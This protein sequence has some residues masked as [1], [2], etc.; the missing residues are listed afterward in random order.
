MPPAAVEASPAQ[1]QSWQSD[2]TAIGTLNASQGV[3][4]TPEISGRVTGVFFHSGDSVQAGTPLL[5]LNPDTLKAQLEAAKAKAELSAA[6]YKRA[7]EL[8]K[9]QV[10]AQADLDAALSTYQS[11]LAE[12]ANYQAQLNQTLLRAPFA[13]RLGLRMVDLGDYVHAGD[14]VA[15]LDAIDPLRID[16][17]VPEVDLGQVQPGQIVLVHASAYPK[18]TFQGQV[19]ALDSQIEPNT[20]SLGVR[21]S[22]PNKDQK[23]LPGGFVEVNIQTG[24]PQKLITVAETAIS[25]DT[26]GP[27]VY[28]VVDKKAVK[29]KVSLGAHRNGQVAVLTGLKVGDVV[30]TAGEFKITDGAPVMVEKS[31]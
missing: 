22:I 21:A 4:V 7:T 18:Q 16:F 5:Q 27:Y 14:T 12:V 24:G 2:I 30:I 31:N 25:Y 20:R 10:F 15:N 26:D 13:G 1:L 28:K 23:L 17:R 3:V 11:D 19:Y 29:T 8:F 9:K 6:N